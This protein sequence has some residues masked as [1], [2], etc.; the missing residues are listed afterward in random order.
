MASLMSQSLLTYVEEGNVPAL[1]ALLEKCRD[2]D[3]RNEVR[4]YGEGSLAS[5][6]W[7]AAEWVIG[8]AT[9]VV[10]DRAWVWLQ[11]HRLNTQHSVSA[12]TSP[13]PIVFGL[14]VL[15]SRGKCSSSPK[16]GLDGLRGV[17]QP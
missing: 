14:S 8:E 17:C 7:L 11:W 9:V 3:E 2:V 5:S 12:S 10:T 4:G 1:K 6:S 15:L 13:A 16:V